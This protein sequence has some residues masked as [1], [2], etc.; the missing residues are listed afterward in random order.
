LVHGKDALR[1]NATVPFHELNGVALGGDLVRVVHGG[2]AVYKPMLEHVARKRG[3]QRPVIR[4]RA[5][6]HVP[7]PVLSPGQIEAIC[8]ACARFDAA[9]GQWTGQVRDRLLWSL[10][11]ETGLRLGEALGLQHGDWHT[12]PRRHPVHRGDSPRASARGPGQGRDLPAGVH[13]R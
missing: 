5:S 3:R 9:S 7:P 6:R 2:R 4:V 10:L 11:A 1:L 12:G 13:L 8:E